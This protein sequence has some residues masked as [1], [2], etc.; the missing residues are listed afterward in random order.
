M[1]IERKQNVR[2]FN[3]M[4]KHTKNRRNMLILLPIKLQIYKLNTK[5]IIT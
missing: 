4:F 5:T 1:I 3:K 2:K